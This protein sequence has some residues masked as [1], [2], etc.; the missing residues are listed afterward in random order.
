MLS[1]PGVLS[2]REGARDEQQD[3]GL[4]QGGQGG[5]PVHYTAHGGAGPEERV[6]GWCTR[7]TK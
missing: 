2:R 6:Q 4:Q 3:H 1:I 7:F 5:Q